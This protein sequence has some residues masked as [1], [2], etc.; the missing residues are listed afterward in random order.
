VFPP[1]PAG[2]R[3]APGDAFGVANNMTLTVMDLLSATDAQAVNGI[4]YNGNATKRKEAND[5]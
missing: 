4:L 1:A 5:V 2:L 3:L